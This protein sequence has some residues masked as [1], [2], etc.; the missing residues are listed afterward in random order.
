MKNK[1]AVAYKA[2]TLL[3]IIKANEKT[4]RPVHESLSA[5]WKKWDEDSEE[6]MGRLSDAINVGI[7]VE[8]FSEIVAELSQD[9]SVQ[10][11]DRQFL[12]F[13]WTDETVIRN[14]TP[15]LVGV[16]L[17]EAVLKALAA[18]HKG[19]GEIVYETMHYIS[20]VFRSSR[21]FYKFNKPAAFLS[22]EW[23]IGDL[24]LGGLS[25]EAAYFEL[26]VEGTIISP[27]KERYTYSRAVSALDKLRKLAELPDSELITLSDELTL[28]L[29]WV[30]STTKK[31]E[32]E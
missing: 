17:H 16:E 19:E 20:E 21:D 29:D 32:G 23:A 5:E 9:T 26:K 10:K 14:A 8:R 13:K 25:G 18:K 7:L 6:E 11:T 2:A 24:R 27:D 22:K 15:K 12:C 28:G 1:G 30:I 31:L 3:R 4:I